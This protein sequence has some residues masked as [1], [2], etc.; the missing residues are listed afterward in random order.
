MW[1]NQLESVAA[2]GL[3]K[4]YVYDGEVVDPELYGW[5][6]SNTDSSEVVANRDLFTSVMSHAFSKEDDKQGYVS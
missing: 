1:Y 6:A 5:I 3:P 4:G 2:E